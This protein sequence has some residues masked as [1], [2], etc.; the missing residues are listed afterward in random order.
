MECP[1]CKGNFTLSEEERSHAQ[2]MLWTLN[3]HL[4][5]LRDLRSRLE[6]FGSLLNHI[7][8]LKETSI[9]KK[10]LT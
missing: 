8:A 5:L 9:C 4:P 3:E 6:E 7:E 10:V 1:L 2:T